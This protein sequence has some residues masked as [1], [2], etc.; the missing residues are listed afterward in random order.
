M[1]ETK[2]WKE[3]SARTYMN[4]KKLINVTEISPKKYIVVLVEGLKS[5][6]LKHFKTKQGAMRFMLRYMKNTF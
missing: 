1:T 5:S 3:I 2:E 6:I 4:E